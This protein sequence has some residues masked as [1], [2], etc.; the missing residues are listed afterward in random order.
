MNKEDKVCKQLKKWFENYKIKCWLNKGKNSF[1]TK[2]TQKKPDIIIYSPLQQKYIAIEVKT[3]IKNREIYD[4]NKIIEYWETY[5]NK[6]IEYYIPQKNKP[7]IISS[8]TVA[9]L[10][11]MFGKLFKKE[12]KP[13][14]IEQH[15]S[16]KWKYINKK[17]GLEPRW[18]YPRTHDYLRFLWSQWR[19]KRERKNHPGLGIILS[20]N[21]NK[22]ELKETISRPLLFDQQWET[23]KKPQW[24]VRQKII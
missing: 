11:S 9:T 16:D 1:K 10:F 8:F 17:Y 5:K 13:M 18:E 3:G 21:L 7:I 22:K 24:K 6:Q 2:K 20:N 23:Y 19:K 14:S 4:A 12:R 15:K